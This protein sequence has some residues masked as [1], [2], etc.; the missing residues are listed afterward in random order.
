[1][2]VGTNQSGPQTPC[3]FSRWVMPIPD[4]ATLSFSP[5]HF[6]WYHFFERCRERD[7]ASFSFFFFAV[8]VLF[9]YH[10]REQR[11]CYLWSFL[12]RVELSVLLHHK[13]SWTEGNKR[14]TN[15][16][17]FKCSFLPS[18][19]VLCLMRVKRSVFFLS[20][21]DDVWLGWNEVTLLFFLYKSN[22][23][24]DAKKMKSL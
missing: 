17:A 15:S 9:L 16:R 6:A 2:F 20:G 12:M 8:W 21:Q 11:K 23:S 3:F 18:V 4:S 1:M 14:K 10:V 19:F 7:R 24:Y 13:N 22:K 5:L